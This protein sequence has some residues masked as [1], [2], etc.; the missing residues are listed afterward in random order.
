MNFL[1]IA[2]CLIAGLVL[3]SSGILPENSHRGINAWILYIALPAV[4]LLYIPAIPWSSA[5]ILPVTMPWLVWIGA[6]LMLKLFARA[7]C[8]GQGDACGTASHCRTG[9]HVVHRFSAYA[10]ILR[11]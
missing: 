9:K 2:L 10:G 5:L 3:R 8:P 6:W 11:R 4:T 1:L 7:F